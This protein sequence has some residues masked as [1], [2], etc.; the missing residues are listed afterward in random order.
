[1]ALVIGAA[2]LSG[3]GDQRLATIGISY[4]FE[5]A[6]GT[7]GGTVAAEIK[8]DPEAYGA[9]SGLAVSKVSDVPTRACYLVHADG[10]AG[11]TSLVE[12]SGEGA[13]P[14]VGVSRWTG[15]NWGAAPGK[16]RAAQCESQAP[17]PTS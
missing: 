13:G 8:S 12:I 17:T 11:M 10:D 1:V 3:V 7:H 2:R 6:G 15:K 5:P 16:A 9:M 4:D 14:V